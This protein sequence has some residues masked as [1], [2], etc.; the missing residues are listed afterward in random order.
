MQMI[1]QI[2]TDA[3]P[4]KADNKIESSGFVFYET[5]L[6]AGFVELDS[7]VVYAMCKAW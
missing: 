5:S 4:A 6:F 7:V 1:S 2:K 3:I